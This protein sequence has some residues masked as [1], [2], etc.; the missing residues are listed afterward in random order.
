M[1]S[2]AVWSNWSGAH[3]VTPKQV[4][5]PASTADISA[6][7][8]TAIS[9]GRKLR[10]IGSGHSFTGCAVAA[11]TQL[12]L[13]RHQG[14]V[15]V[16]VEKKQVTLRGGTKLWQIPPLL[17]PLGLAMQNLG[18]INRQSITGAISTST[19]GTG[20]SFGGL[21]SQVAGVK[22]IDGTGAEITIDDSDSE[23][24]DK[25][26]VTLGAYGVIS[27][28]T[29]QLV[30]DYDLKVVERPESLDLVLGSWEH[31][32]RNNDHFEFFWFAEADRVVTK[33][34][35]RVQ[36][37]ELPRTPD[38]RVADFINEELIGN[39]AFAG[40]VGVGRLI[41]GFTGRLNSF[42]TAAWGSSERVRNWSAGFA[43]PRRVK[44]NE[45]EYAVPFAAV[46]EILRELR[47]QFKRRGLVSTFPLEVRAAAADTGWLATSYGRET[48]YIAVHKP[49]HEDYREYFAVCES[50]FKAH[51]GRPHWGK[52]HSLT[53]TDLAERY[54][55]WDAI[56]ELR[57]RHDP[58]RIFTN[59]YL[60]QVFG[61]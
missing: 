20:L 40:L 14:V 43:S 41:P 17:A 13:S 34:S 35:T 45:M 37:N 22:L 11:D 52:M 38:R 3:Q 59:K 12:D 46:P 5:H 9:Q 60:T 51:S 4:L 55:R 39:A 50:V 8:E 21:G 33:T 31:L 56:L 28:V 29:L 44:F 10:P 1:N 61:Y 58:H 54:D 23:E 15:A 18:D 30:D 48:G 47:S 7:I 57:N 25:Y 36:P 16:D 24:L 2:K 49:A 27:E 42:A 19:H 6:A 53:D 32:N 26:R